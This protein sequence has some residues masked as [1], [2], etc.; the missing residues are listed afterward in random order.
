[1]QT[2]HTLA[3]YVSVAVTADAECLIS[4]QALSR[5]RCIASHFPGSI[6]DFFGFE[7][8]L[9]NDEASADFLLCCQDCQAALETFC[10]R[11]S[12]FGATVHA[13]PVWQRI[14]TFS[15]LWSD[16]ASPLHEWV[17]N[18]WMEFD[19]C[20]SSAVL[21]V[22]SLFIGSYQL[23]PFSLAVDLCR[24]PSHCAWLTELAMPVLMDHAHDPVV[25][26][27]VA[28]CINLLPDRA[29]VF[30]VGFM[31]P[32]PWRT[33]RLCVRGI[34]PHDI[35]DYLRVLDWD[36][37]LE[38]LEELLDSFSKK[39]NRVDLDIDVADRVLPVIGL[40]CYLGSDQLQSYLDSLISA[41]LCTTTKARA[42]ARW[43]RTFL[44]HS[45]DDTAPSLTPGRITAEL[46]VPQSALVRSLHHVKL[47]YFSG[48][49]IEAKAYLGVHRKG[50]P[51]R[52]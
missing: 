51:T 2:P 5:I 6:S 21:P 52:E 23:R 15:R 22:P 41:K 10:V 37:S 50:G 16:P 9:G 49:V 7:S 35:V 4:S 31:L 39:V 8:V 14:S 3:D 32:R 43:D 24:M 18:L 25:A 26:D 47:V 46:V 42:V 44:Q 28:R 48:K 29:V 38:K 11:A 33:V 36:G 20:G 17:Q 34:L 13:H 12:D 40:E 1:M 45:W 30:Q 19:I 27:Q